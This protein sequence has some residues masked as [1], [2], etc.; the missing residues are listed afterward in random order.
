MTVV[1]RA[2]VDVFPV[3]AAGINGARAPSVSLLHW[4]SGRLGPGLCVA[5]GLARDH[6]GVLSQEQT[7]RT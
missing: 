5:R 7:R 2:V 4:E 3:G 1:V 6:G